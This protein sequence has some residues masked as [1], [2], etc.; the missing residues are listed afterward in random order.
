MHRKAI[1]TGA[2]GLRSIM[3]SILLDIMF[4]LPS[5]E[6]P[7]RSNTPPAPSSIRMNILDA[8]HLPQMRTSLSR[9]ANASPSVGDKSAGKG[10][11]SQRPQTPLRF[12]YRQ[13]GGS[14]E[15]RHVLLELQVHDAWLDFSDPC[16]SMYIPIIGT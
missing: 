2:R 9:H 16:N 13:A 1:E 3:E 15:A 11:V 7:I 12:A 14:H 10:F 5:L 8:R 6:G 4:D